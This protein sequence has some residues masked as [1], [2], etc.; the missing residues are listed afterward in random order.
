MMSAAEREPPGCPLPAVA[1]MLTTW[2]RS[3][4]AISPSFGI[5]KSN[6][7]AS[8]MLSEAAMSFGMNS[9][10]DCKPAIANMSTLC[11]G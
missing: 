3:F 11:A 9:G 6:M 7:L 1:V 4:L 2:R 5:E 10:L 8:R